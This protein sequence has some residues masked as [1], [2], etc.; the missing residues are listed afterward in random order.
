[1]PL[2]LPPPDKTQL[3][4]SPLALVVCQVQFEE[5]LQVSDSR[6]GL[7]VHEAL[8]A[9]KGSYPRLNA[10]HGQA[11]NV[12]LGPGGF[13][14]S[15]T[16]QQNGWQLSSEDGLWVVAFMPS[17]VALETTRY[18]TWG[19]DFR[20]RLAQLLEVTSKHISPATEQRLGLRYVDHI[21]EPVVNTPQEWQGYISTELLGPILHP[22]IGPAV[23]ASQ[24]Q[25]ELDLGDDV[26]SILRHG[27]LSDPA[28]DGALGYALDFDISRAGVRAF[29]VED[30]LG[31]VDYFNLTAL[32][33][34]QQAITPKMLSYLAT[35]RNSD[36]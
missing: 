32:Q 26:R 24:Q 14:P 6:F 33:L 8:G 36:E 17:Y 18:T 25:V 19:G 12:Q 31:A 7:N 11:F 2:N 4:R 21:T 15:I 30:I 22:G 3:P 16:P 13:Q 28:R 9:R 1:M 29:D 20:P 34:F 23:V 5:T 35:E 10:R 27:F